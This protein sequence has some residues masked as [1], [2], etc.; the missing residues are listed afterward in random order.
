[1]LRGIPGHLSPV[2]RMGG[3]DLAGT[4]RKEHS[5]WTQGQPSQGILICQESTT[6]KTQRHWDLG[7][8]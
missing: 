8:M 4:R 5:Q 3:D 1:M 6:N 7:T 2:S